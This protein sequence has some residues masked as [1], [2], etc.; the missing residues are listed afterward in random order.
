MLLHI[1]SVVAGTFLVIATLL[2]AIQT[3]VLPRGD[4]TAISRF[5]FAVTDR[6]FIGR[7]GRPTRLGRSGLYAP[8][9][10]VLLP[11]AWATL[12]TLGFGFVF[13]GLDAAS[14]G[15]SIEISGSSLFTLGFLKP[16]GHG[17]VVITFLEALIGLGLVALLISFLPTLYAAYSDREKGVGLMA[18][19]LGSP[20]SAIGLITGA[21]RGDALSSASVWGPVSNWLASLEQSHTSFPSLCSFPP[22]VAERSWVVTIGS[23]LD[24]TSLLESCLAR[25]RVGQVPELRMVL[26]HGTAATNRIARTSSLPV[27]EVPS[28]ADELAADGPVPDIA[29]TRAEY[30]EAVAAVAACGLHV[31]TDLDEGWNAFCRLRAG[32]EMAVLGLA[33]LTHAP[34]APWISDRAYHVGRPRF[35]G[36][37][38]L[39][40]RPSRSPAGTT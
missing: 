8:V 9:S 23:V 34:S 39:D 29:V 20:P 2:S 10:L 4:L 37:R 16:D 11:L 30:D 35:F 27:V 3:V 40:V 18:P 6:V 33:G 36:R 13:W 1:L 14:L 38:T 28:I 26:A 5:V 24:A 17:L 12:V 22:Q 7:H 19:L 31:R 25:D 21:S 32:Y 15:D